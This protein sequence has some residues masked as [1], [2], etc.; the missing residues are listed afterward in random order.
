MDNNISI[1][2]FI[3]SSRI[4]LLM[5][6]QELAERSGVSASHISRIE[7]G[8]RRPSP[9]TLKKLSPHLEVEYIQLLELANLIKKDEAEIVHLEKVLKHP[10][11]FLNGQLIDENQRDFLF[12][13]IS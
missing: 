2:E 8:T 10:R 4:E 3:H 9:K 6:I 5:S 7:K 13:C 11:L 1:H 12:K